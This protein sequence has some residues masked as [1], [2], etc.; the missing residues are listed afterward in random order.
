MGRQD[1][2]RASIDRNSLDC[3]AN[4]V[5]EPLVHLG[6]CHLAE[7]IVQWCGK[8]SQDVPGGSRDRSSRAAKIFG[9]TQ[10]PPADNQVTSRGNEPD[11]Q[12]LF[13]FVPDHRDGRIITIQETAVVLEHCFTE[14]PQHAVELVL[15]ADPLYPMPL[16]IASASKGI[17]PHSRVQHFPEGYLG[18]CPNR[19]QT[20][21]GS[22]TQVPQGG[23]PVQV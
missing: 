19:Q 15:A 17:T 10:D 8:S 9:L 12:S 16:P 21:A 23:M 6:H 11:Q 2:I 4:P 7:R 3:R 1:F 14:A 13:A 20:F 5:K 18:R 22:F